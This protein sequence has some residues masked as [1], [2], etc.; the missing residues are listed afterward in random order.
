[1]PRRRAA[2]TAAP[3]LRPAQQERSRRSEELLVRAAR[4]LLRQKDFDRVTIG[5]IAREAGLSVGGF[6][7]RFRDKDVLLDVLEAD[8][9]AEMRAAFDR[10]LDA[11]AA[12]GYDAADVVAA[13]VRVMV[14]E[15][16]RH[17]REIV[18]LR[19]FAGRSPQSGSRRRLQEFNAHVHGRLRALLRERLAA[20][21]HPDPELAINLGLFFVSASA[22]EA[23]LTESLSAYPVQ[24]SETQLADA[25]S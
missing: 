8:L 16:R 19:R 25:T 7:A 3:G 22:R 20:V 13:Y 11:A 21:R 12:G 2:A 24:P 6:Y 1:M 10:A 14:Q 4:A 23:L 18:Q 15:L 17:R 9:L 5:E